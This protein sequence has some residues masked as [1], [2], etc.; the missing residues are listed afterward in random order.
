MQILRIAILEIVHQG[1]PA[2]AISEHVRLCKELVRPEAARFVNG[3]LRNTLRAR[4]RGRQLQP[5]VPPPC[6][7]DAGGKCV[8]AQGPIACGV[9]C[10]SKER[11]ACR[12][13]TSQHVCFVR[14]QF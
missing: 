13:V 10:V 3:V 11:V 7:Q 5:A 8:R 12:T 14:Q 2:H 9:K 6:Q 4:D 1:L